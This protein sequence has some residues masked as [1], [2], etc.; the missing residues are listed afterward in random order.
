MLVLETGLNIKMIL[1]LIRTRTTAFKG[2]LLNPF[3][4]LNFN[5]HNLAAKAQTLFF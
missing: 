1:F 2:I 4:G 3:Q 5:V